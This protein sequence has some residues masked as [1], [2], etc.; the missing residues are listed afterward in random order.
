MLIATALS[1]GGVPIRI[2]SE[3]WWHIVEARD[4]LAGR[5]DDILDTIE[6]PD[7]VT[8]GYRGAHVAWKNFGKTGYLAVVYRERGR[9]DGFVMTAFFTSKPKRRNRIWP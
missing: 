3:R 7:W 6:Q 9:K 4:D 8:R 5:T 2:T 1:V